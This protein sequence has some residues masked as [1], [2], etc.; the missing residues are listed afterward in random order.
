MTATLHETGT[1]DGGVMRVDTIDLVSAAEIASMVEQ[2]VSTVYL[3]LDKDD[4]PRPVVTFGKKF[5]VYLWPEVLAWVNARPQPAEHGTVGAYQRCVERCEDCR[6]A[7]TE[8][9][10]A[11]RQRRRVA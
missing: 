3:W 10:R 7:N 8:Y 6:R 1:T 2:A 5:R 11:W 9:Q 4:F